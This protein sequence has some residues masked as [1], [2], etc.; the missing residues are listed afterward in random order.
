MNLTISKRDAKLLLILLGIIILLVAYLAVY[1]P[2]TTR[3]E[4]VEAETAALQPQLQE[5]QGYYQNI[6]SYYA[7]IDSA[8]ETVEDE[9]RHYPAAVRS[10]D[11]IMYA[12]AMEQQTGAS[13]SGIAFT[14]EEI[15]SQFAVMEK[16][17]DGSLASRDMTAWR[18]GSTVNC[19]L[20]YD[21]LKSLID[22]I[23]KSGDRTA[24]DIVS[25]T[26]DSESGGLTGEATFYKYFVASAGDAYVPAAV[27]GVTLGR[28]DLFGTVPAAA[29]TDTGA[30]SV[31]G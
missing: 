1:N 8:A 2:Y 12:I 31:I 17:A 5:L 11:V 9:L 26:Y 25:V 7:G 22:Y 10:E 21:Q 29:Q 16:A 14:G 19:S 18:T 28:A 27:P 24:L 15:V 20:G 3:T 4:A 13:I 23:N 6:D 30:G